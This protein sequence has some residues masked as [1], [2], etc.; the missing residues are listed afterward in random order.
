IEV[1][2]ENG[3]RPQEVKNIT[4]MTSPILQIRAAATFDKIMAEKAY[5][6]WK[7]KRISYAPYLPDLT[8]LNDQ[9][10]SRSL[11]LVVGEI[12]RL[13]RYGP[14]GE[15]FIVGI[16]IPVE[17]L[18]A[19]LCLTSY[20]IRAKYIQALKEAADEIDDVKIQEMISRFEQNLL[21]GKLVL[22]G[23]APGD[24]VAQVKMIVASDGSVKEK[25]FQIH[26]LLLEG[27]VKKQGTPEYDT[28]REIL[29]ALLIK[30]GGHYRDA[31]PSG[32]SEGY[33]LV[34][35][36]LLKRQYLAS[37][38][39]ENARKWAAIQMYYEA[40]KYK[41]LI[42]YLN[43]QGIT[44]EMLN[45]MVKVEKD[46]FLRDLLAGL[47]GL[48]VNYNDKGYLAA[49]EDLARGT[50]Y[51]ADTMNAA[52][53]DQA[54]R[55]NITTL[56]D[57][58][59][60]ED[61]YRS[62]EV[63]E[64]EKAEET[65]LILGPSLPV[66]L[67]AV[68]RRTL[69]SG[70]NIKPPALDEIIRNEKKEK[71][72]L[73]SNATLKD[74]D[75]FISTAFYENDKPVEE[76]YIP[77]RNHLLSKGKDEAQE[78]DLFVEQFPDKE[79]RDVISDPK[80]V[81]GKNCLIV[82]RV[83]EDRDLVELLLSIAMLMDSG[84][85]S[86]SCVLQEDLKNE[87][88]ILRI[89]S[90][91]AKIY[92][93]PREYFASRR[94][95]FEGLGF[96]EYAPKKNIFRKLRDFVFLRLSKIMPGTR[97][98]VLLTRD[99]K[100]LKDKIAHG[101]GRHAYTDIEYVK[102]STLPGANVI[103]MPSVFGRR[104]T[105]IHSTK[106]AK[107]IVELLLLLSQL[108]RRGA[109]EVS[110][111]VPYFGYARG[112]RNHPVPRF[113]RKAISANAAKLF[114]KIIEGHVEDL[115][116]INVHF[117]K[118][119]GDNE[120][121]GL[122][123]FK[124]H[125]LN[126]FLLLAE[127]FRDEYGF[128]NPEK[129]DPEQTV[130][131]LIAPDEGALA[132][133]SEVAKKLG[134]D[135]GYFEK[136]RDPSTG[137]IIISPRYIVVRDSKTGQE[138]KM[139]LE[140]NIKG[141]DFI[142]LDDIIAKGTTTIT[143]ASFLKEHGANRIFSG[144]IHGLFS[145]GI[146]PF[147]RAEAEVEKD[148]RKERVK[149]YEKA[150][151]IV[152]TDSITSPR[153]VASLADLFIE[154]IK[155]QPGFRKTIARRLPW[156]ARTF[157]QLMVTFLSGLAGLVVMGVKIDD[158][159]EIEESRRIVKEMLKLPHY[160]GSLDNITNPD[161]VFMIFMEKGGKVKFAAAPFELEHELTHM[162]RKY[163]EVWGFDYPKDKNPGQKI[164]LKGGDILDNMR[165][166]DSELGT[167]L[168]G[169]IG[170]SKT[171]GK[172]LYID[173]PYDQG[174][175]TEKLQETYPGKSYEELLI[176]QT[177]EV[178]RFLKDCGVDS[179]S[180]LTLMNPRSAF[181][182]KFG[183]EPP[184]VMTVEEFFKWYDRARK[185][186]G[187]EGSGLASNAGV[188]SGEFLDTEKIASFFRRTATRLYSFPNYIHNKITGFGKGYNF[189][190]PALEPDK[191]EEM[192]NLLDRMNIHVKQQLSTRLDNFWNK[193][194]ESKDVK[195]GDFRKIVIKGYDEKEAFLVTAINERGLA[196]DFLIIARKDDE[197]Y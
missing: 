43:E 38:T 152:A 176:M 147:I 155:K 168:R 135:Y 115:Y 151:H 64:I 59:K 139:E 185:A 109:K 129:P 154:F 140:V 103:K 171:V 143:T 137:D 134:W 4:L 19:N 57:K 46:E 21:A 68:P 144:C 99:Y 122:E 63:G 179:K 174:I 84:A 32:V 98:V 73:A 123:G 172:V 104:V 149:V 51:I 156:K 160:K 180:K 61:Y 45:G 195:A 17:V 13:Q 191:K 53:A 70:E 74:I 124:I 178:I 65:E 20:L 116:T 108:K 164:K 44:V 72:T 30:E 31:E 146:D 120:F 89:I 107:G 97:N 125:N 181:K 161:I 184:A 127:H 96:K 145:E 83:E 133:V 11:D 71:S 136:V 126:A 128:Y 37:P 87:E 167:C 141:R 10:F 39:P 182:K 35:I 5:Q 166:Y 7:V 114:L 138:T 42:D 110:L 27:I 69:A 95:N 49:A 81:E 157:L 142:T 41:M 47:S 94:R 1:L 148:G 101:I 105:L 79:L 3:Y 112:D 183:E 78:M 197:G 153:S 163:D 23:D 18:T 106:T 28:Y 22:L 118:K 66:T 196:S 119:P 92:F 29:K 24:P 85:K 16:E 58:S 33:D 88:D 189:N 36:A 187:T 8:T 25:I 12:G 111:I 56:T 188:S 173:S 6:A 86:I 186:E 117:F 26:R 62:V 55:D 90:S 192:L 40:E 162:E 80:T 100:E 121:P 77:L 91:F 14:T 76:K 52:L 130:P 113:G 75:V 82:H 48:I 54:F 93:A 194:M 159:S 2:K 169:V 9:E 34:K 15:N 67:E 175:F 102:I 177:V 50:G 60:L 131:V 150:E 158:D 132:F 190:P 165:R 193:D 170:E